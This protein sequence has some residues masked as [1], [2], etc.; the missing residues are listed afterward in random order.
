MRFFEE[1]LLQRG[2]K[3]E[4][5]YGFPNFTTNIEP[6]G[7]FRSTTD[8]VE[9]LLIKDETNYSFFRKVSFFTKK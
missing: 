2:V 6:V 7:L 3:I 8:I 1:S 9:S 4:F 5:R